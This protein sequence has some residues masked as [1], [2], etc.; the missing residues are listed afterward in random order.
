M[1]ASDTLL[2]APRAGFA[3]TLPRVLAPL[4]RIDLPLVGIVAIAFLWIEHYTSQVTH[5]GVMTD[6]L[7]YVRMAVSVGEDHTFIPHI[8]GQYVHVYSQVYSLLLAPL[9]AA[10]DMGKAYHLA[11]GLNALLMA[12]TAVP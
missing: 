2:Q 9:Y 11:H 5:W 7:Q 10:F 8:H 3:R 1:S 4:R 12:S 6:E